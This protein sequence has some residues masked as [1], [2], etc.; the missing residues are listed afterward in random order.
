VQAKKIKNHQQILKFLDWSLINANLLES[1]IDDVLCCVQLS[2][3][4]ISLVLENFDLNDI[5]KDI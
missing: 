1:I 4:K 3:N 5:L 2:E